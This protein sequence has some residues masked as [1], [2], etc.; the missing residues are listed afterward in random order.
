MNASG[1]FGVNKKHLLCRSCRGRQFAALRA[2]KSSSRIRGMK[3]SFNFATKTNSF[4]INADEQRIEA[5][6]FGDIAAD[7]ELL[8][9]VCAMLDSRA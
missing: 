5:A 8:L 4:F 9:N 2:G 3:P 7:A 1:L 6:C